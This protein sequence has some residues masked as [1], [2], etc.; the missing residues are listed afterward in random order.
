MIELGYRLVL[1]FNTMNV[2]R[3][4][5]NID[6]DGKI[7]NT[8]TSLKKLAYVLNIKHFNCYVTVHKIVQTQ[9]FNKITA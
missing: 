3:Y 6:F 1:L 7:K 4:H 5:S 2:K 9:A 8:F